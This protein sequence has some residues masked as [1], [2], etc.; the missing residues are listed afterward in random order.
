[1]TDRLILGQVLQIDAD[2]PRPDRRPIGHRRRGAVRIENGLIA[3]IGPA[4]TLCAAHPALPVDD[5][6]DHLILPG[7]IDAHAHY[8]RP[9]SS[10]P[11]ANG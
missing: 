3:E 11:G 1:M 5:H 4:E 6:G 9:P 8:P 7:F 10:P 2:P